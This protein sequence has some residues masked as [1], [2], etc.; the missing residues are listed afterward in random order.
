MIGV[1]TENLFDLIEF[2]V[3]E[4][5]GGVKARGGIHETKLPGATRFS[6]AQSAT[7]AT[8]AATKLSRS[9]R[10]SALPSNVDIARSG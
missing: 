9:T 7:D 4:P 1:A 10:P 3:T 2:V 5:E 6:V 8:G